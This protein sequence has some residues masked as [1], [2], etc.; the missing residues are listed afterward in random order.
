MH[1]N[2]FKVT[3]ISPGPLTPPD[4]PHLSDINSPLGQYRDNLLIPQNSSVV[5]EFVPLHYKGPTLV[6][7]HI[8]SHSDTGMGFRFDIVGS[9]GG[10]GGEDGEGGEGGGAG[11]SLSLESSFEEVENSEKFVGDD[12]DEHG[13]LISA[14]FT[15]CEPLDLCV[16]LWKTECPYNKADF[17]SAAPS[18]GNDR[19]AH[20]C[21]GSAGYVWCE[22]LKKCVR[23]WEE[24]CPGRRRRLFGGER[25]EHGCIGSAGYVWCEKLKKCVRPW[26]TPCV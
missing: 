13:C 25:D 19:D 23:P 21:I 18:V 16:R 6:H 14:G 5:I 9:E 20:G 24:E 10:E 1:T 2:H 4:H 12:L 15:Y 11:D 8:F 7:C 3:S 22:K 26:I 17:E